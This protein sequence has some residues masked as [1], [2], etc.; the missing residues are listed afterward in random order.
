MTR[1]YFVVGF[2]GRVWGVSRARSPA[3]RSFVSSAKKAE[4][5]L[6]VQPKVRITNDDGPQELSMVKMEWDLGDGSLRTL[7]YVESRE[8]KSVTES[9]EQKTYCGGAASN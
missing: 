4:L 5:E 8:G 2:K 7:M 3:F 9:V 6:G 1:E